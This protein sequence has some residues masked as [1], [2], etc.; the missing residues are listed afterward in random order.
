MKIKK[1]I[2]S[3]LVRQK[4]NSEWCVIVR[5]LDGTNRIYSDYGVKSVAVDIKNTLDYEIHKNGDEAI[6]FRV[7]GMTIIKKEDLKRENG[8]GRSDVW[9]NRE[10]LRY[11]TRPD[12]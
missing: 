8:G 1:H 7:K 10:C 11:A 2:K 6:A 5:E 12:I 9:K 4:K 3:V